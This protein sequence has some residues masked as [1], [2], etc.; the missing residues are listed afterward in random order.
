MK[1]YRGYPG[2]RVTVDDQP[3]DPRHD[4]RNHS[5][6]GFQWG[7]GGSGPGQLALA[8]CADVLGDDAAALRSYMDF[9]FAFVARLP[10]QQAWSATDEELRHH[11]RVTVE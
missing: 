10:Q 8:L 11:I 3:L 7:Y 4:L 1:T 5:P 9:K 6:D 2:G